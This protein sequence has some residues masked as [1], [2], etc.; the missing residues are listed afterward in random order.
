LSKIAAQQHVSQCRQCSIEPNVVGL[1]QLHRG[2]CLAAYYRSSMFSL[3]PATTHCLRLPA[4][5]SDWMQ[6][7]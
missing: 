2:L 3:R 4:Q 1:D 6:I 5:F 7:V